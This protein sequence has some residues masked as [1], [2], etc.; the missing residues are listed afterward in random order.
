MSDDDEIHTAD[1]PSKSVDSNPSDHLEWELRR[2]PDSLPKSNTSHDD[3]APDESVGYST[4]H[5]KLY[6]EDSDGNVVYDD[7]PD[8]EDRERKRITPRWE[9]LQNLNDSPRLEQ[10]GRVRRKDLVYNLETWASQLGCTDHQ[11]RRA[12]ELFGVLD[13]LEFGQYSGEETVLALIAAVAAEDGW[14]ISGEK[15]YTEI[16]EDVGSNTIDIHSLWTH[17][18]NETDANIVPYQDS[19]VCE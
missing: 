1:R 5:T 8:D 16:V 19:V 3:D 12:K 18:A 11:I 14:D 9:H 4:A 2:E 7:N 10:R 17:L 6:A 15:K 13:S